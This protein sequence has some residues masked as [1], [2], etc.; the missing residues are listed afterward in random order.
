MGI[1]ATLT[2]CCFGCFC[3]FFCCNFCCGKYKPTDDDND[4]N[5]QYER[6]FFFKLFIILEFSES[7]QNLFSSHNYSS[8]QSTIYMY[9]KN[10]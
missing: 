1:L 5:E 2:C 8:K 4:H 6:N 3:C 7:T 10:H 9:D